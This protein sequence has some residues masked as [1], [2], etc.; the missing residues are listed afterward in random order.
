M[1]NRSRRTITAALTAGHTLVAAAAGPLSL[2]RH[3]LTHAANAGR[4]VRIGYVKENGTAST[5]TIT[6]EKVW[7]SK[8][9]DW[10]LRATCL[11]RGEHR[12]FHVARI[13]AMETA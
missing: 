7:R 1:R 6:P 10:C 8:A 11:L 9:G 13:T 4:T 5:R 2:L 12:T 3:Q